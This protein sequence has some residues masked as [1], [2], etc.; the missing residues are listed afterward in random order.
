MAEQG[1]S[2]ALVP[3]EGDYLIEVKDYD[4]AGKATVIK[5]TMPQT[6]NFNE[7]S[8]VQQVVMLKKGPWKSSPIS[9]IAF[10]V[11]FARS[12]GLDAMQG[13]VFPTSEGRLG[14][15]NKAKI[16]LALR[17]GNVEGIEVSMKDTGLAITLPGCIQKTDLECTVKVYV[18]GWKVPITRTAKLSRWYKAKNPNWQGNPEHMLELNTVAHA[19]EYVNPGATD[20]EEAP[21]IPDVVQSLPA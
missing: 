7:W 10:G 19:M 9:E 5:A 14:I 4:A 11:T 8:L 16:K 12:L 3:I 13:D 20:S 2:A 15:S 21:P 18:K 6:S 1:N 17:T